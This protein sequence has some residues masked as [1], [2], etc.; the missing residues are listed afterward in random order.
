ML[1]YLAAAAVSSRV[2][3]AL[4]APL[5]TLLWA[6]I[7]ARLQPLATAA[8]NQQVCQ[9]YRRGRAICLVVGRILFGNVFEDANV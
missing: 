6:P 4:F 5:F 8:D 3:A 9:V 2:A 1:S 7:W